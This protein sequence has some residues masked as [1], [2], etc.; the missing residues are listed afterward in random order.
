MV[1]LPGVRSRSLLSVDYLARFGLLGDV[2]PAVG[3]ARLGSA[4]S[5]SAGRPGSA[6]VKQ[7]QAHRLDKKVF[8]TL[9][10]LSF[11]PRLRLGTQIKFPGIHPY[12][13]GVSRL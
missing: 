7:K 13:G 8:H 2:R 4:L 1:L 6:A 9:A 10:P 12:M 5:C 3:P 11:L